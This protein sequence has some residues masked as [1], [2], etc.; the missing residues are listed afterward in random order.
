MNKRSITIAGLGLIGGSLAKALRRTNHDFT[1]IGVDADRKNLL[2]AEEDGSIDLAADQLEG[3]AA[4]S[5]IIFLC[6]PITS[7]PGLLKTLG[8][9]VLP[10]TIIS[11]AGSIKSGIMRQA[12]QVLPDDVYFIGGHPMAGTERSG[13]SNSVPHLFENA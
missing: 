10:G 8:R 13:Y 12:E 6:T 7:I 11:D 9:S 2:M 1:I 3:E 4:K 5:R